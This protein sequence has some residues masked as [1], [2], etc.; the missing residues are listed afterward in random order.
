[1]NKKTILILI[2]MIIVCGAGIWYFSTRWG[3]TQTGQTG[4]EESKKEFSA[5]GTL[6]KE[7]SGGDGWVL[8]YENAGEPRKTAVLNFGWKTKC[9]AGS[10]PVSCSDIELK[11]GM[12][13]GVKGE[14]DGDKVS[15]SVLSVLAGA[16]NE[17]ICAQ[18]IT[19]AVNPATGEKKD[20]PTPCDVPKGWGVLIK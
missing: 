14:A 17:K 13:V 10:G 19:T 20:F 4:S 18:V 7:E 5:N 2:L 1:M 8:N 9:D 3:G 15:I 11:D 6:N 16:D 12:K